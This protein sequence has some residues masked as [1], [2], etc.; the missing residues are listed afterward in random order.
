MLELLKPYEYSGLHVKDVPVKSASQL[1]LMR[2]IKRHP[3]LFILFQAVRSL[4]RLRLV[5]IIC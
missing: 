1:E 4:Y 3:L 2:E 5:L